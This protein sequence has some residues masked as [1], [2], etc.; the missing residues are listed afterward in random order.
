MERPRDDLSPDDHAPPDPANRAAE[1]RAILDR[2]QRDRAA[3]APLYE[4]YYDRIYGF[5]LR[6][7]RDRDRAD[8][9]T[10]QTFSRA[11]AGLGG[12]R[13]GTVAGWLFAIARNVVVDTVRADRP[14]LDLNTALTVVDP[15][16]LPEQHAINRE[17]DVRLLNA[18]DHLTPDQRAVIDLRMAGL[19]GAEVADALGMTPGAVRSCQFRAIRALRRTLTADPL[20]GD[21]P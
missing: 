13:G 20:F 7:L 5:C 14:A 8:D 2:S 21:L 19:S 6:R 10:G 9:A 1:E 15:G 16:I 17:R 3:F 11:L 12:F 18:I 4:R